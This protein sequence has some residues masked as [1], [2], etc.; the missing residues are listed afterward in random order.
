ME[1]FGFYFYQWI[2]GFSNLDISLKRVFV[3]PGPRPF[4]WSPTLALA[5]NL[6]LPTLALHLYYQPWPPT[7]IYQP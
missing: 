2:K 6:Y 3:F 1:V 7:C 5:P 4:A